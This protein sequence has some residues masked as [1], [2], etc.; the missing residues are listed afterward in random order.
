V[1]GILAEASGHVVLGIGVNVGAAPW[2]GAGSVAA[3]R[4]ELLVEI[5]DRLDRG[6]AAWVTDR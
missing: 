4:L 1:A 6:Y 5:L 3:D 2:P